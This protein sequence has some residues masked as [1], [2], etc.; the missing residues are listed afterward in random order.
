MNT[1]KKNTASG[2][3]TSISI[4]GTTGMNQRANP[5]MTKAQE[6]LQSWTPDYTNE[7]GEQFY[8]S[9]KVSI[10]LSEYIQIRDGKLI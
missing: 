6:F 7:K 1:I 9:G 8:E 5:Q 4:N 2:A 10:I 3:M